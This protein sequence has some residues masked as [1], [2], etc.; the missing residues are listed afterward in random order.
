M[1]TYKG[2]FIAREKKQRPLDW[3]L[4]AASLYC[5]SKEL[6]ARRGIIWTIESIT[7]N[8]VISRLLVLE[9]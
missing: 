6:M 4:L 7:V 9:Y 8:I 3:L 5:E 1:A 2:R